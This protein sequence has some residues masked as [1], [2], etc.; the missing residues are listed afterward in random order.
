MLSLKIDRERLTKKNQ[1][2]KG[3]YQIEWISVIQ[4]KIKKN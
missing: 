4:Y 2:L 1:V 3:N